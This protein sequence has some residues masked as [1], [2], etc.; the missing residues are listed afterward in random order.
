MGWACG[1]WLLSRAIAK[2]Q[3]LTSS[4]A[5]GAVSMSKPATGVRFLSENFGD[6]RWRQRAFASA[7]LGKIV[8]R[9]DVVIGTM[10]LSTRNRPSSKS[11]VN[12]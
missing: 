4:S 7:A 1:G 3:F 6:H 8:N 12:R 10:P 11:A 5:G 2:P 9:M